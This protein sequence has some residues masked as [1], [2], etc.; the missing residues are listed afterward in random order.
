MRRLGLLAL[1][2][3]V[4]GQVSA[5]RHIGEIR[6]TGVGG[7]APRP[8]SA[9]ELEDEI[10]LPH[11]RGVA[12]V[13]AAL[14]FI[15]GKSGRISAGPEFTALFGSDRRA[16]AIRGIGRFA[17]GTGRLRPYLL[18]GAGWDVWDRFVQFSGQP[19]AW[20]NDHT[21]FTLSMGAGL[22]SELQHGLALV[23][24]ARGHFTPFVEQ[25]YG[26]RDLLALSA[27]L[28]WAW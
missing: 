21:S 15:A 22:Q 9:V 23:L 8:R 19:P 24:E 10:G 27:G 25:Y 13:S 28:R 6:V 4:P 11:G 14:S 3:A 5:Q 26:T 18:A 7:W 16:W 12:G 20:T 1:L 2:I 17:L